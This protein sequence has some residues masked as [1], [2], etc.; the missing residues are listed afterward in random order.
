MAAVADAA[1]LDFASQAQKKFP[2]L[3]RMLE[4]L[5]G[6]VDDGVEAV[7]L[8]RDFGFDTGSSCPVVS[9]NLGTFGGPLAAIRSA[10]TRR[11]CNA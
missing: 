10:F 9:P 1:T 4:K 8:Y 3:I 11:H 6:D 5:L 2:R 7:V